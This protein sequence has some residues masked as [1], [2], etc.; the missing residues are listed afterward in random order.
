MVK[1]TERKLRLYIAAVE[2]TKLRY[3]RQCNGYVGYD[4]VI[5]VC[6]ELGLLNDQWLEWANLN[7]DK[8]LN[9]RTWF[10][11]P[12]EDYERLR[13]KVMDA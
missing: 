13:K 2:K 4:V 11:L 10:S 6:E 12:P 3:P 8:G 7:Q 5:A 9:R 1:G